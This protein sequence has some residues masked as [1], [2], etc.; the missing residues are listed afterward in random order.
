MM[1]RRSPPAARAP[2]AAPT[3]RPPPPPQPAR[4][5]R[6]QR[7]QPLLRVQTDRGERHDGGRVRGLGHRSLHVDQVEPR[8]GGGDD[9]AGRI[10]PEARPAAAPAAKKT[11]PAAGSMA[12]QSAVILTVRTP[13][14][15]S[16]ANAA[17]SVETA[18]RPKEGS[19]PPAGAATPRGR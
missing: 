18:P 12:L 16:G 5:Q 14:R 15:R 1:K 6:G 7:A 17:G 19:A 3:R 10:R 11:R 2:A 4:P 8:R 9:G 13:A